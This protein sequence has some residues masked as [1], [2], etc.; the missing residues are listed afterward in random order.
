VRFLE[1]LIVGG[2]EQFGADA[3]TPLF[4]EPLEPLELLVAG[5]QSSDEGVLE[6]SDKERMTTGADEGKLEGSG[7]EGLLVGSNEGMV[8][9]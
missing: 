9:G 7:A 4:L 1:D 8:E 2:G 6:G 5:V 3:G